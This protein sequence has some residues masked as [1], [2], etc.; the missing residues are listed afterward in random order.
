MNRVTLL[1]VF[2]AL[3]AACSEP[4]A[5]AVAGGSMVAQGAGMARP[6]PPNT[7]R[8]QRTAIMDE[9]GGAQ[10]VPASFGLI[11]AGWTAQGGVQWGQQWSCT[12]GYNFAWAA[13]SP[14]GT[15]AV[16]V[17][18][19]ARWEANNYGAPATG[20][21]CPTA[22]HGSAREYMESV[23]K[24]SP[25]PA[26][27]LDYRPRPDLVRA[28]ASTTG[29]FPTPMGQVKVWADAGDLLFAYQDK[30]RDMR[31]VMTFTVVF[32]LF[33]N[34]NVIPGQVMQVLSGFAYPGFVATAPNGR[35]DMTRAEVIRQSFIPNPAWV[36]AVTQH[37]ANIAAG[38]RA[39]IEKR[40]R[41]LAEAN[42]YISALR[43]QVAENR[44]ASEARI[45]QARGD[46]MRDVQ[47]Y[48][49]GAAPGGQVELSAFYDNA[50]RLKDGTYVLTT[51]PGFDLWRDL[52]LEGQKL[53]PAR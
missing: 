15:E 14:D 21:N 27:A 31:G 1:I 34:P 40:G 19:M 9:K 4:S 8:L 10:P 5:Q 36:A 23:L 26:R 25:N 29:T 32:A 18:P 16:G 52:G 43:S 24:S 49:D 28:F 12:N 20:I 41:I 44:A 42:D 6:L 11:P 3:C 37:N 51:S 47:R 39:E 30:G 2:A 33:N 35:L 13:T 38:A 7:Y 45:S 50:W 46:G 17:M 53:E 22:R 48:T